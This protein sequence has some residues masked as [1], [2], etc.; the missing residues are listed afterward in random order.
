[1]CKEKEK[2]T[3]VDIFEKIE[4]MVEDFQIQKKAKEQL[5]ELVKKSLEIKKK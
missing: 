4:K 2:I 3:L 5:L 1:M